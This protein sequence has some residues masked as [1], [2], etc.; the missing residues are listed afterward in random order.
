AA[1]IV[2]LVFGDALR[3]TAGGIA[4]GLAIALVGGRWIS[5]LLFDTSV[6]DPLVFA[7]V[8]AALLLASL[9]AGLA[10]ARRAARVSPMEAMRGE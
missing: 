5:D 3:V 2:R 4:A 10:P 9:A 8:A 7:A 6:R 1:S